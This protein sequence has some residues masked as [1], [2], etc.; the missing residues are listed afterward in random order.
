VQADEIDFFNGI[1]L[2]VAADYGD[3]LGREQ[4]KKR[5]ACVAFAQGILRSRGNPQ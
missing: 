3:G 4:G 5:I 2:D 1:S